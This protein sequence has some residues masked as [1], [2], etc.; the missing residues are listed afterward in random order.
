LTVIAFD[1]TTLA[2]DRMGSKNPM[3][4]EVR[5]VHRIRGHLIGWAG[6]TDAGASFNHWFESGCDP[7]K[8]PKMQ[9]RGDDGVD[10]IVISPEGRIFLYES[11]PYPTEVM[12]RTFAIGSGAEAALAVMALGYSAE[13]AVEI[14]SQIC[15]GCGMG[16]DRLS[17]EESDEMDS[18]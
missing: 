15:A 4:F 18:L 9:E 11:G 6:K 2:G 14:A 13:K 16:M 5:K 3:L 7:D 12:Q 1:G 17:L 8:Y 10:A